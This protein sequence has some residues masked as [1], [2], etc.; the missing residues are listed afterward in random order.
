MTHFSSI[1]P[2]LGREL[3]LEEFVLMPDETFSHSEFS[4]HKRQKD[5]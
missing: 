4:S 5:R 3:L 1:Y 2:V